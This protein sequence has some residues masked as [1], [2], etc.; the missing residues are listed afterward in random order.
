MRSSPA[1]SPSSTPAGSSCCLSAFP[2][3]CLGAEERRLPAAPTRLLQGLFVAALVTVG[4]LGFFALV[5]LPVSYGAGAIVALALLASL[6]Q[7]R[8]RPVS[9]RLVRQRG[10]A[11]S[12][13][14]Q[15]PRWLRDA[16]AART[17][18]PQES[19]SASAAGSTTKGVPG[20][21]QLTDLPDIGQLRSLFNT[22]SGEPRLIVLVSPT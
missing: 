19:E 22:R 12:S 6:W 10:G 21:R 20:T 4:F 17:P 11:A 2:S 13:R 7:R 14:S 5:G 1:V 18:A 8:R 15:L 16:A 3:Y 9:T